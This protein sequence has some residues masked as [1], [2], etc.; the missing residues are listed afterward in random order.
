M[1]RGYFGI[2]IEETKTEANIGL[3]LRSAHI[4]GA[5]FAFTIGKRYRTRHSTDTT[6]A[7]LTIP[8]Y[9]YKDWKDFEEY[10]PPK[11]NVVCIENHAPVSIPVYDFIHPECAV[12]LLGAEDSGISSAS[13]KRANYFVHVPSP[14]DISLNVAV[15]GSIVLAD[16]VSK[17]YSREDAKIKSRRF[18]R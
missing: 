9:H 7:Q 5:K 15:A 10:I 2:G 4:F 6:N 8:L 16:R 3:L 1:M 17:W 14:V 18:R 13:I 11:C 12:Y